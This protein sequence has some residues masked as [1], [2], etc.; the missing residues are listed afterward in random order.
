MAV[1]VITILYTCGSYA[2]NTALQCRTPFVLFQQVAQL[3]S[4]QRQRHGSPECSLCCCMAELPVVPL[5]SHVIEQQ[6]VGCL[7][8]AYT[9]HECSYGTTVGLLDFHDSQSASSPWKHTSQAFEA[10]YDA[11]KHHCKA[12]ARSRCN[13]RSFQF[14]GSSL[15]L[16]LTLTRVESPSGQHTSQGFIQRPAV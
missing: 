7:H 4:S 14:A 3:A 16:L 12:T 6:R 5:L 10:V 11:G 2:K 9:A 13:F 15:Q 8:W 1:R